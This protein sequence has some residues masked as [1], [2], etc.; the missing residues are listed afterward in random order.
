MQEMQDLWPDFSANQTNP[1]N[2]IRIIEE[3]AKQLE[4]KTNKIVKATFSK[5]SYYPGLDAVIELALAIDVQNGEVEKELQDKTDAKEFLDKEN[6]KFEIYSSAYR[7]RVFILS[8]SRL[9]PIKIIPDEVIAADIRVGK[10]IIVRSDEE[11]IIQLT[12]ILKSEKLKA[13]IE[14]IMSEGKTVNN[15]NLATE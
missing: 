10:E 14:Q 7:F 6:Y 12:S 9:Y 8:Y 1:N 2:A 5:L 3:Q 13:I 4:T 11:L 15:T